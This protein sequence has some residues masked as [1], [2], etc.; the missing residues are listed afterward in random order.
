MEYMLV[1][2]YITLHSITTHA[3]CHSGVL[4]THF[5]ETRAPRKSVFPNW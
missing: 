2:E 5:A 1:V 4:F 3:L